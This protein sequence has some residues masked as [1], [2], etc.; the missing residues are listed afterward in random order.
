[1]TDDYGEYWSEFEEYIRLKG[2]VIEL[3]RRKAHPHMRLNPIDAVPISHAHLAVVATREDS[4]VLPHRAGNRVELVLEKKHSEHYFGYLTA[5]R[6]G[7]RAGI[8]DTD[9]HDA[10]LGNASHIDLW[11][12]SRLNN[13]DA[14]REDFAWLLDNL[15]LFRQ[16]LG[17]VVR[18][19]RE[20]LR[21]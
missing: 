8:P 6:A 16:V 20:R 11:N 2:H 10:P 21:R 18:E 15:L 7:I 17:P 19:A 3:R 12:R 9:W 14:W 5:S 4:R 13:R 1:M